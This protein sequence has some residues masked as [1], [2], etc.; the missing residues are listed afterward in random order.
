MAGRRAGHRRGRSVHAVAGPGQGIRR[1]LQR[2]VPGRESRSGE[3]TRSFSS[4][5]RRRF[6]AFAANTTIPL[7]P[8]HSLTGVSY[9][10]LARS[11]WTCD[12]SVQDRS[13]SSRPTRVRSS[14]LVAT[15]TTRCGPN[16]REPYFDRIVLRAYPSAAEALT[17]VFR[18]GTDAIGGLSAADAVRARGYRTSRSI[19][20]RRPITRRCSSTSSAEGG[21]PRPCRAPGHRDR[22]R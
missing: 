17:A 14:S 6:G 2:R 1:C 13:A 12:P 15:T 9:N 4:P 16:G 10:E 18:G 11:S 20:F 19:A 5:C 22:D 21:L 8:A 7:M 3:R